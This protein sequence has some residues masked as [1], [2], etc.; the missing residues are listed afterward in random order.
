MGAAAAHGTSAAQ[1]LLRWALQKGCAVVPKTTSKARLAENLAVGGFAL[2]DTE[3]AALDAPKVKV[4][5][6]NYYPDSDGHPGWSLGYCPGSWYCGIVEAAGGEIVGAA[7]YPA[8]T[9]PHKCPYT[10]PR[11]QEDPDQ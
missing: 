2:S 9:G 3:V 11:F 10:P 5:W 4:L 8:T 7:D 6:A 1:V